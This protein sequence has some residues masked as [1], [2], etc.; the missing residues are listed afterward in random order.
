M[1][2]GKLLLVGAACAALTATSAHAADLTPIMP[3]PVVTTAPMAPPT[4]RWGGLYAGVS[5]GLVYC[6][7]LC[8]PTIGGLASVGAGYNFTTGRL[9][10]GTSA[11][12][13]VLF[14]G[15][16]GVA[17][18][19]NGRAGVLLGDRALIYGEG[20]IGWFFGSTQPHFTVGGGVEVAVSNKLSVFGEVKP[21]WF[22]NSGG[23]TFGPVWRF[24]VGVSFHFGG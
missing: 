6:P 5:G 16:I 13:Y 11:D 22:F 7:G 19:G 12:L 9:L 24:D 2:F 21:Y 10:F 3:A 14:G 4:F 15:G 17:V 1:K 18:E 23:I 8:I 20:G